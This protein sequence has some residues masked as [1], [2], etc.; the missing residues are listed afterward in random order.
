MVC[1]MC[2]VDHDNEVNPVILNYVRFVSV[3]KP[4]P[5]CGSGDKLLVKQKSFSDRSKLKALPR[6]LA[7]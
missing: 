2:S 4:C 6:A 1:A 5:N 3:Q 7:R